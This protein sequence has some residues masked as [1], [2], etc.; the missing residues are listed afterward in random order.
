M[1]V[2]DKTKAVYN[3]FTD[4]EIK[5]RYKYLLKTLGKDTQYIE[6]DNYYLYLKPLTDNST[7]LRWYHRKKYQVEMVVNQ[8]SGPSKNIAPFVLFSSKKDAI[9]NLTLVEQ[10]YL[11]N[12]HYHSNKNK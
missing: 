7:G 1:K 11:F 4:H 3:N 6:V 5:K 9:L 10:G 8:E 12:K 2:E